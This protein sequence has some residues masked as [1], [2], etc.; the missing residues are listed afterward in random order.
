MED[1]RNEVRSE[2]DRMLSGDLYLAADEELAAL[3]VRGRLIM[4]EFNKTSRL[5]E[6]KRQ[7]LIKQLFKSVGEDTTI[8]APIYVDYGSNISIGDNFYANTNCI[9]LDVAP[10]NIGNNVMFGPRV[11]L[12]TASHPLDS[13]V[14]Q[15]KLEL[16]KAINIGDGCWLGGNVTVNP[17]ITIANDSIVASGSV[18]TKDVPANVI[19]A[20]NPARILRELTEDDKQY[21]EALENEYHESKRLEAQLIEE[22]VDEIN[23]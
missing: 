2:L 20:G 15:R 11:N 16:G 21:W 18:V 8:E 4:E 6:D 3:F 23:E 5:E 22:V 13:Q 17:G 1:K 14:R 9:F 19:V 7:E 12:F 10:I